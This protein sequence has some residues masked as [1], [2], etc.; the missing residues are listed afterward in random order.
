MPGNFALLKPDT[1]LYTVQSISDEQL[2]LSGRN[3]DEVLGNSVF[4]VYSENSEA[5]SSKGQRQLKASLDKVV[6]T[7]QTD[8]LPNIR[9]DFASPSGGFKDRYWSVTNKPVLNAKG[10]VAFIIHTS[11]EVARQLNKQNELNFLNRE[12]EIR[13]ELQTEGIPNDLAKIA[14]DR[15]LIQA[16]LEQAP[17]AMC[18]F[19]GEDL[20]VV[21]ANP[22]MCAIWGRTAGQ[23]LNRPLLEGVPELQGQGFDELIRQVLHSGEPVTGEEVAAEMLRDGALK[24]T[25]YNFVYQPLHDEQGNIL[26]VVDVAIEVTDLVESRKAVEEREKTL[27]ELNQQLENKVRN[28]T[29]E[30]EEARQQAEIQWQELLNLFEQA[31]VAIAVVKGPDYVISIANQKVCELWGRT[32][33][34]AL[35]KPLF[36]LIPEAADQGFE[37]LLDRV[38]STGKPLVANEIASQINR[39]GKQETAYWN[40]VYY[41]FRDAQQVIRGVTVI[42]TEVTEQVKAR[43]KVETGERRFKS[44]LHGI[45]QMTWTNL[46]DGS[47]NFF[48]ERWY[49]YTGLSFDQLKGWGWKP[50]VHPEDLDHMLATYQKALDTGQEFVHE[51]RL[52]RHDG[53]YRWHLNRAIPLRNGEG[54]IEL[55]VGTSTDIHE[56]KLIAEKLHQTSRQL[57]TTNEELAIANEKIRTTNEDLVT[58][59]QKLSYI[60]ADMDSFIYTASHDLKAPITNI[61]GLVTLLKEDLS[62]LALQELKVGR[63][64]G[65]MEESI[66]RFKHTITSLSDVVKLQKEEEVKFAQISLESIIKD[67]LLDLEPMIRKSSAVIEIDVADCPYI[68]FTEKNLRSVVFNLI[69]NAIKYHSSERLPHIQIFCEDNGAYT[70][71][72]VK[73]NGIGM[74]QN[75][76]DELFG[77]FKRF[78]HHVEGSG[79]GLHMINKV[80]ENAGGHIEVDSREGEGTTFRVFFK[81]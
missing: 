17:V 12:Q 15:R 28:R 49:E 73:D 69:S 75:N 33:Q 55:W 80:V 78:H 10:E 26:G 23:V 52:L 24:A 8:Q 31:P 2:Q 47:V 51:N 81:L 27:L 32:Q 53:V 18:L 38:V 54:N 50:I 77:M 4:T 64:I 60:N 37:E 63:I 59:N 45:P 36:E 44:L 65:L 43:H 62:S 35:N 46:P 34:E 29:R 48:S 79:V 9:Y 71:L 72:T 6:R 67:V 30:L 66:S 19:V 39:H 7:R 41:P 21:S 14:T 58:S 13:V 57:A 74:S 61:E 42:S 40:F 22:L 5:S 20:K 68:R 3:K 11:R 76:L 1:P 16:L 25:Y 70:I 56:Q